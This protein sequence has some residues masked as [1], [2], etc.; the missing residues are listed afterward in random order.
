[1]LEQFFDSPR[2]AQALRNGPSEVLLEGFA[3]ELSQ[4]GYSERSAC[5]QIR[6]AEHF[7]RWA[8][9][10]GIAEAKAT[11]DLRKVSLW[12]GHAHMT[13]TEIYTRAD[14]SVKLEALEYVVAPQLRS[15]RFR[16]T[17][18]LTASLRARTVMR[19]KEP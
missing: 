5:A 1:M 2:R 18:Q 6:A 7:I 11:K 13:T 12:L 16:A 9:K 10:E 4:L 14:P 15:G 3:R 19:G 8:N 17:D